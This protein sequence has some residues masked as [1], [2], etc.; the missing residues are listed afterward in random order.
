MDFYSWFQTRQ[1]YFLTKCN[2]LK[3][4]FQPEEPVKNLQPV[5]GQKNKSSDV[6]LEDNNHVSNK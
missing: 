6:F 5:E 3:F 2:K 1:G 4:I